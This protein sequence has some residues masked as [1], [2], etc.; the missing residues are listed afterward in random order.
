MWGGWARSLGERL[1]GATRRPV[2]GDVFAAIGFDPVS[3][4]VRAGAPLAIGTMSE[5]EERVAAVVRRWCPSVAAARRAV[6][7][8]WLEPD[9]VTTAVP[10]TDLVAL[11]AASC[12][13]N[14][15]IAFAPHVWTERTALDLLK[16]DLQCCLE[17]LPIC[18]KLSGR[19][20]GDKAY[21]RSE[22]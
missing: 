20:S 17:G 11:F 10:L 4:R 19:N 6:E 3:G 1:D 22:D 14:A 16:P 2:S 12:G 5:I 18:V 15:E 13:D 7:T 9:P 8:A 21:G